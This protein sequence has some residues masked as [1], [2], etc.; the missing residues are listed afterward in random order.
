MPDARDAE[1]RR[2]LEEGDHTGL[3]ESYHGMI[4]VAGEAA[5][6][7]LSELKRGCR[8]RVSVRV[9]V[10]QVTTWKIKERFSPKG[11]WEVGLEERLERAAGESASAL[12]DDSAFEARPEAHD[13]LFASQYHS[14]SWPPEV[15][16]FIAHLTAP[17][18]LAAASP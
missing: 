13:R 2:R 4:A 7:L 3:V 12:G 5:S 14:L 8:Y 15:R 6:R 9:V 16:L 11:A 1:D 10:H 18:E 17:E